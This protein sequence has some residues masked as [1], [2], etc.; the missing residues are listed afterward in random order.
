MYSTRMNVAQLVVQEIKTHN[1]IMHLIM[2]N[3]FVLRVADAGNDAEHLSTQENYKIISAL[4][5]TSSTT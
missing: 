5:A 1:Q 2:M 4:H 3:I